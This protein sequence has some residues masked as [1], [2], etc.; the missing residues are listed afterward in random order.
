[1]TSLLALS[2]LLLWGPPSSA[3]EPV[4]VKAAP[5]HA[6]I[7]ERAH[8]DREIVYY[9]RAPETHA[10]DLTHDYTESRP[11]VDRYL[12]VV[13]SGSTVSD[14]SARD[15]DRGTALE[16]E[17]LIGDAARRAAQGDGQSLD[18]SPQVV[19]AHFPPVQRG[20][21]LRLRIRETYTDPASYRLDGEELVLDRTV[22]RPRNAVVLPAGWR[23]T[24]CTMPATVTEMADGRVRLDFPN[25]RPDEL[26][27]LIKG[28]RRP[29]S[30]PR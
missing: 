12:N 21:S 9:L 4:M 3:D 29:A 24:S 27:L 17:V 5:A 25:A 2:I 1:L 10:F 26:H 13:R 20:E 16:V 18:G 22:G 6:E 14:P 8:Q 11:G 23:L 19:V 15:L 30:A 7:A 28:K